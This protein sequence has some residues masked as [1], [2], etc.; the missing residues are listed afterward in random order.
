[1]GVTVVQVIDYYAPKYG[2]DATAVKIVALGEGGLEW[3]AGDSGDNGTSFGPFQLHIGGALPRK[4]WDDPEAGKAFANSVEG[5]RYALERMAEAGA[6]GLTGLDA[7]ETIIRRFER[8]ADPDGS[9]ANARKRYDAWSRGRIDFNEYDDTLKPAAGI[10][11]G[12]SPGGTTSGWV[13]PV[14]G[15]HKFTND[16]GGSRSAGATGGTGK[17]QGTDIFAARGTPVVAVEDGTI[18]KIG[19]NTYGGNRIWLN[20]SYYYAHLDG[21][22]PG[23]RVGAK[24]KAG[25]VIGYVGN[26]GDARTTPPHLHF[27]YDPNGTHGQTWENPY[28]LL[29][30][31]GQPPAG[32][33]SMI[34]SKYQG[35]IASPTELDDQDGMDSFLFQD[36]RPPSQGPMPTV[37]S[38][39]AVGSLATEHTS[40]DPTSGRMRDQ[41]KLIADQPLAAPEVARFMEII[42]G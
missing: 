8:P 35:P 29:T 37:P 25:D 41:W 7:I 18:T 13:F 21:Y 9:F 16:W 36:H 39:M 4:Y 5:V 17:H 10:D 27:G 30:G 3:H 1:M 20:G 22:A 15:K 2:L 38:P 33:D 42:G 28:P 32:D 14:R 26:T 19:R 23:M 24:V 11:P 31:S 6:K 12:S 40:L 34:P